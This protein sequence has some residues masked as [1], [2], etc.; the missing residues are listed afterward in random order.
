MHEA[1]I[2]GSLLDIAVKECRERGF[3]KIASI[4]VRVGKASGVMPEA[5]LFAFDAMKAETIA[6]AASLAIEE[7]PV[8]GYCDACRADFT[9]EEEFILSCPYCGGSSFRAQS[10]RELDIIELEV[11]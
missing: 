9:V 2:V 8:S 3:N 10:G 1:S 11:D 6:A 5:L 4:S 7:V